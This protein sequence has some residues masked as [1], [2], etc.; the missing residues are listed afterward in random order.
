MAKQKREQFQ[1]PK[2]LFEYPHL[3]K[4]DTREFDD[5]SKSKP[6]YKVNLVLEGEAM[7]KFKEFID[8]K[9]SESFKSAVDELKASTDPK[10]KAKAKKV[11]KA[12][13]YEPKLDASGNETG[14]MIFKFK[15]NAEI[16][17]KDGTIKQ[18][19]VDL[20]DGRGQKI[21]RNAVKIG[22]GSEGRIAF[23][24]RPYF[25]NATDKAGVTLDL[26]AAMITALVEYA[27]KSASSYGFEIEEDGFD[28]SAH[29]GADTQE[30]GGGEDASD[31]VDF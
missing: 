15:Q 19:V 12:Y 31:D 18:I 24:M 7:E 20:F 11:E 14:A 2:G 10:K 13:P 9:V 6:A 17:L 23:T 8:A 28:A 25:M 22:G 21:D 1:T 5:G 3:N 29:E 26:Q 4:P 16:K 30:S 27:G